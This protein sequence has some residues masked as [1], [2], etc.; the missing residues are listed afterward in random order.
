M[1]FQY[2]CTWSPRN[3]IHA[4]TCNMCPHRPTSEHVIS[5]Y[6]NMLI[7]GIYIYISINSYREKGH[8]EQNKFNEKEVVKLSHTWR[9]ILD[10]IKT[11]KKFDSPLNFLSTYQDGIGSVLKCHFISVKC[12]AHSIFSFHH[13]HNSLTEKKMVQNF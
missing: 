7:H 12:L 11:A 3:W 8:F 4:N 5:L 13:Y 9:M 6:I 1:K 2:Q 10:S